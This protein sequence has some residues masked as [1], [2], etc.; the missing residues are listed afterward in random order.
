MRPTPDSVKEEVLRLWLE[1]ETYRQITA[2]EELSLGVISKIVEEYRQKASDIDEL[3][4]LYTEL[5]QA[6]ASLPDALRGARFL[7]NLDEW[8]F[9]SKYLPQCLS[10]VK[11]AGEGAPELAA[12]GTRLIEL[13]KNAGKSYE[14]LLKEF[15]ERV[16][17]E[18]EL[19]GRVN[20]FEDKELK[21]R[22]S[23]LHLEKLKTLQET[24]AKHNL[25]PNILEHLISNQL[26]LQKLGFTTQQA[27][28]LAQEL[29]KRGLNPATASAQMAQLLQESRDLEDAKNKAEA[30]AKKRSLELNGLTRNIE[31]TKEELEHG[32][33]QV[34]K[35]EESYN[36][37]KELLSKEYQALESKLQAEHDL[38]KQ[39]TQAEI[40]GLE[41]RAKLLKT[42]VEDLQSTKAF[43]SI[44]EDDLETI[45]QSINR[46]KP[47]STLVSLIEN[48]AAL[49]SVKEVPE[50]MLAIL[51]GFKN[52]LGESN[53]ISLKNK[54][55]LLDPVKG[56]TKVLVEELPVGTVKT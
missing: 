38:K 4:R 50:V 11:E 37:R 2:R 52:Y 20:E 25:T 12:A 54:F 6:Q 46:S 32:K 3:R 41:K 24:I 9:D 34:Q 43:I 42:E 55:N 18:A 49:K 40:E 27:E 45:Q 33:E 48:P 30:E 19:S 36:Y 26:N 28:I 29:A 5:R 44:A 22:T 53:Q 10:F 39:N 14:Q 51:S 17:V 13:E 23:I 35:L 31:S 21:L 7:Q 15:N 47:L 1:G 16:K 56:L 8:E